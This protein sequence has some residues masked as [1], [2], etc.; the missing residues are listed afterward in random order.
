MNKLYS[1]CFRFF[2]EKHFLICKNHA[3]K[4]LIQKVKDLEISEREYKNEIIKYKI[5][6]HNLKY[7]DNLNCDCKKN[8][9]HKKSK[10]KNNKKRRR[11]KH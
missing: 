2:K 1:L 4:K 3:K 11:N 5:I 8:Y 7:L 6:I 9:E 10:K